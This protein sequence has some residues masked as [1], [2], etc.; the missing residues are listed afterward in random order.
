MLSKHDL[1]YGMDPSMVER[2]WKDV[3]PDRVWPVVEFNENGKKSMRI[4]HPALMNIQD[5]LG[6]VICSH[7]QLPLILC[8]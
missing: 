1:G 7:M 2:D 8:Y 6:T 3:H 4:V 5:N